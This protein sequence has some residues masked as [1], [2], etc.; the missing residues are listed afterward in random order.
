MSQILQLFI[1][2]PLFAF[3][4][5]M[6]LPRKEKLISWLAIGSTGIHLAGCFV[7]IIYW[8]IH[9]SPILDIKHIVLYKS[10]SFE[11]FIDFYFDKTTAVFSFVGSSIML[12]V[13]TF[14]RY[15]LHRDEGFKRFFNTLL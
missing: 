4:A 15:Y 5:S 7:F 13:S 12:L 8:M 6:V 1:L 9:R 3:L 2:I 14:S 11:F 10:P